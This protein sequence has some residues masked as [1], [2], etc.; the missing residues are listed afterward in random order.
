M[1]DDDDNKRDYEVGY[2]RP[3]HA[4]RFKPKTSGNPKGRPRRK[5]QQPSGLSYDGMDTIRFL[6]EVAE[7]PVQVKDRQGRTT[8]VPL[9]RA[10]I[11]RM[12]V[13]A[14]QGKRGAQAALLRMMVVADE[15]ALRERRDLFDFALDYQAECERRRND[16]IARGLDL[17][18]FLPHPVDFWFDY[19]AGFVCLYGPF[20]D[21]E[22]EIYLEGKR[23]LDVYQA[24]IA[25]VAKRAR[26]TGDP[27]IVNELLRLQERFDAIN[28]AMP[29][30]MQQYLPG[31]RDESGASKPGTRSP[32]EHHRRGAIAA[33]MRCGP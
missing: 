33:A 1:S 13:D 8:K 21:D 22:P 16:A 12:G 17:P 7:T 5:R 31:R 9:I 28:D 27:I 18:T 29:V 32:T 26:T 15:H 11:T 20:S 23:L 6:R 19:E 4:S 2:G 14:V 25:F 30:S 10:A 24:S 3:P